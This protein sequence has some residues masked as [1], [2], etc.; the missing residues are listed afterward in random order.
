MSLHRTAPEARNTGP[1]ALTRRRF[2][3][4]LGM[5]A[6]SGAVA[7]TMGAWGH[8]GMAA[9]TTPPVMDGS[10]NGTK[11]IVVGAGPGGCPAAYEL[12]KLG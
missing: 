7:S 8:I 10:G 1:G 2:L 12:M 6:G 4:M 9:Q 11:V 3:Q 5:T